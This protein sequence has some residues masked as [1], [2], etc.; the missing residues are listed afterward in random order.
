MNLG[1]I[2]SPVEKSISPE[3]QRILFKE[4][5]L[6]NCTYEKHHKQ[7]ILRSTLS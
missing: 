6:D 4:L 2:G 5:E 3:L 1:L 7:K